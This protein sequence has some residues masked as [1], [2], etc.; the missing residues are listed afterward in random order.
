MLSKYIL[1]KNDEGIEAHVNLKGFAVGNPATDPVE[2]SIGQV[3]SLFGHQLIPEDMYEE[4]T[5]YCSTNPSLQR[6]KSTHCRS[7]LQQIWSGLR[8]ID[9]YA[10]SYPVCVSEDKV[11]NDC[12]P[13][14]P[15]S[16]V[17]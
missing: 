8:D 2:Q 4:W 11:E 10:L 12:L 17:L 6:L 1:E 5:L 15:F 7:L 3:D 9:P 16:A 14:I 13:S